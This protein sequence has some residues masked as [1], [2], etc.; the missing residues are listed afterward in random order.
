[1]PGMRGSVKQPEALKARSTRTSCSISGW[2]SRRNPGSRPRGAWRCGMR[3]RC[4]LIAAV[5]LRRP[6]E[7]RHR[8]ARSSSWPLLAVGML[9]A[10]AS[11]C[12]SRSRT[13]L[14]PGWLLD[15]RPRY[16]ALGYAFFV[17]TTRSTRWASTCRVDGTRSSGPS[18]MAGRGPCWIGPPR[19][20]ATRQDVSRLRRIR[21]DVHSRPAMPPSPVATLVVTASSTQPGLGNR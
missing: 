5:G 14:S 4:R 19:S 21:A 7:V 16:R 9:L 18:S 13:S 17:P 3:S 15:H 2:A 10:R 20:E 11:A 6:G 1:M 12:A 8:R